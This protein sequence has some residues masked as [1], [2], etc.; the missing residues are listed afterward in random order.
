MVDFSK[1]C[2]VFLDATA[3]TRGFPEMAHTAID[4]YNSLE[5]VRSNISVADVQLS[6]VDSRSKL[7]LAPKS[8]CFLFSHFC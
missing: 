3:S 7:I 6:V 5:A 2:P 4:I 1:R 8:R